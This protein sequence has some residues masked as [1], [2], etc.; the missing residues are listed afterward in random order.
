LRSVSSLS[1]AISRSAKPAGKASAVIVIS[2]AMVASLTLPASAATPTV[3]LTA[4]AP[5]AVAVAVAPPAA[6][7]APLVPR[8]FGNIGFTGVVKPKPVVVP[9]VVQPA[10]VAV[11]R[12]ITRAPI[13]PTQSAPV[14]PTQSAPV[15]PPAPSTGGVI[16]IAASL[17]G[18]PYVYGGTTTA[19]FDCSGYTQYVVAKLGINLPRTAQDQQQAVTAVSN[20]QPGDLVFFGVPAYH[21]GIYAGNNMMWNSPHSGAVVALQSIWSSTVTYGRP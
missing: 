13:T 4:T 19:G 17:A 10:V 15:A 12:S 8:T 18:I 9:V 14:A 5:V 20:P 2:G 21:V 6:A 7:Q 11:S 1:S 16:G 3:T